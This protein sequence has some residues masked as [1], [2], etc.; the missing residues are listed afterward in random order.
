MIQISSSLS[1]EN[2]VISHGYPILPRSIDLAAYEYV[3]STSGQLRRAYGVTI[4]VTVIGT[5]LSLSVTLMFAFALS[6][7]QMPG[8]KIMMIMV[9]ITMLFNGGL[10]P[11]YYVCVHADL[12]Y[13]GYTARVDCPRTHDECFQSGPGKELFQEQHSSG[14]N[15]S[16]KN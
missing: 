6:Q 2:D 8:A 15:G 11:T 7:D 9:V 16:S 12:P 3:F 10:V 14:V 13:Q 1:N 4:L 5:V